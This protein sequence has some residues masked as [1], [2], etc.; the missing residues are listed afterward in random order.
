MLDN[1]IEWDEMRQARD[2]LE[3]YET[4]TPPRKIVSTSANKKPVIL[5]KRVTAMNRQK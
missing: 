5:A 2:N 4:M 1:F 3:K